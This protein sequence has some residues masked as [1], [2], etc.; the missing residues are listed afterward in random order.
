MRQRHCKRDFLPEPVPKALLVDILTAAAHAPSSKNTQPWQVS[1]LLGASV[2][3]LSARLC[4]LFDADTPQQA[5]YAYLPTPWPPDFLERARA[6]GYG[7]F[8]LKGIDRRD[9]EARRVHDRENFTFFGAPAYLIFHLPE[10][11]ERGSFLDLGFFMQNIMLGLVSRGLASCPQF[12]V[13]G[14]PDA[15]REFLGLSERWIVSG[16]AVGYPDLQAKVN[17]YI[18]ERLSLNEFVSWHE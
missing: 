6:C 14:Y 10:H 12:S 8:Q 11:A 1:V 3:A 2:P 16:L 5:D 9:R 17:G 15:I 4:A 18:P 13:A 7:L